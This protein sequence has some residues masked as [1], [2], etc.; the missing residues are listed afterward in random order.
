MSAIS[1]IFLLDVKGRP[2]IYRDY[3]GDVGTR[4]AERFIQKVHELEDA[5]RLAPVIH[6][7]GVSYVYVLHANVYLLAVTRGNANAAAA[8]SFLHHLVAV[9]K[10][11][12]EE[13]E[14]E[15][16]R[17]NFVVVYELLDEVMDYGYPQFTEA[18]ILSEYIKTDAYRLLDALGPAPAAKPPM[19]VTNAVSWRSEGVRH[20]KNEVFLDVVESVN[21][22][23][24]STGQVVSSEV[25]GTLKMR[26]FLSGMPECKLGLNDK[27]L[28][29]AQGRTAGRQK[30]VDLEDIRFHQCV[31]LVSE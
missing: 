6:D 21:L 27:V 24:S 28:F 25:V 14:E 29:E 22:L 1:A 13:L 17:D 23:V 10:H 12:F 15:S 30:A 4:H 7:D 9:F 8:V 16:V 19:A 18:R 20:K 11:Y 26:T 3:R 2:L 31:R 5:G